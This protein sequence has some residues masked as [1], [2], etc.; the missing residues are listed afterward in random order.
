MGKPSAPITITICIIIIIIG[1]STIVPTTAIT[2][3][4]PGHIALLRLAV[5]E[6]P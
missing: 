5:R 3:S 1:I 6:D 2:A 4:L